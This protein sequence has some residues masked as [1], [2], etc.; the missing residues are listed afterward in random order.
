MMQGGQV[1][2]HLD[3]KICKTIIRK[4]IATVQI[5]NKS[6]HQHW[7]FIEPW[8]LQEQTL[9]VG[10]Q[11]LRDVIGSEAGGKLRLQQRSFNLRPAPIIHRNGSAGLPDK[12]SSASKHSADPSRRNFNTFNQ[13]EGSSGEGRPKKIQ[14]LPQREKIKASVIVWKPKNLWIQ[15]ND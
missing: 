14:K 9:P 6:E 13:Q 5:G 7:N 12:L 10:L 15:V 11:K 8:L 2:E 4:T 1:K 3:I